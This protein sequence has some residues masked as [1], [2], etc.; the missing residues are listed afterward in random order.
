MV[1]ILFLFFVQI[2]TTIMYFWFIFVFKYFFSVKLNYKRILT[3]NTVKKCWPKT[4]IPHW[5]PMASFLSMRKTQ[6]YLSVAVPAFSCFEM[7]NGSFYGLLFTISPVNTHIKK[8]P[9]ARKHLIFSNLLIGD[10]GKKSATFNNFG[11]SSQ[12]YQI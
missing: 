9:K 12:F 8:A 3:H 1:L 10:F 6:W 2:E 5:N 4:T 11:C 7:E